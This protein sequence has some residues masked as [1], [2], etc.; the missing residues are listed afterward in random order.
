MIECDVNTEIRNL[1]GFPGKVRA[2]KSD[3]S[4]QKSQIAY[5]GDTDILSHKKKNY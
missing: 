1:S 5:A 4:T 2:V 3:R